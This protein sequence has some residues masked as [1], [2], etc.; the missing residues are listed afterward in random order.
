MKTIHTELRLNGERKPRHVGLA[1]NRLALLYP[2]ISIVKEQPRGCFLQT[3]AHSCT[4]SWIILLSVSKCICVAFRLVILLCHKFSLRYTD[5][6]D[7]RLAEGPST[8]LAVTPT[9]QG[10]PGIERL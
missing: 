8:R 7:N 2:S 9:V 4:F 6:S 1:E 3:P 5:L 10:V